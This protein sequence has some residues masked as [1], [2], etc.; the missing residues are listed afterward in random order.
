MKTLKCSLPL[1][2]IFRKKFQT[3]VPLQDKFILYENSYLT[4]NLIFCF[5]VEI[6]PDEL[7]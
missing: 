2:K 5:V 4:L 7:V 6:Y 3:L 1:T